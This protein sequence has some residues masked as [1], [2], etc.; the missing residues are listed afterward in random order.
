M[1]LADVSGPYPYDNMGGDPLQFA[2]RS[3]LSVRGFVTISLALVVRSMMRLS[4]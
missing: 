1:A 3:G 4:V 2:V